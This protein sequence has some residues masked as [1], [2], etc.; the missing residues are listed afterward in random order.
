MKLKFPS[1]Q[2]CVLLIVTSFECLTFIAQNDECAEFDTVFTFICRRG[3][4]SPSSKCVQYKQ[5]LWHHYYYWRPIDTTCLEGIFHVFTSEFHGWR[6]AG[7]AAYR[8][9]QLWRSSKHDAA[10]SAGHW[11]LWGLWGFGL[12]KEINEEKLLHIVCPLLSPKVNAFYTRKTDI[13]PIKKAKI[14]DK[15][16][17]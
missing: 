2:N 10:N 5:N 4:V 8:L 7:L 6:T 9:Q 16:G 3:K 11:E 17:L 12:M 15:K 1:T 14:A 13:L